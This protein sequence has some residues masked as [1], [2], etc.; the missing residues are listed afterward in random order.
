MKET[1]S[2]IDISFSDNSDDD[3][4]CLQEKYNSAVSK[5]SL[6]SSN[7]TKGL[8]SRDCI[9]VLESNEMQTCG[10]QR[11]KEKTQNVDLFQR[12]EADFRDSPQSYEE[13]DH[14]KD[15]DDFPCM[16]PIS[17]VPSET[18]SGGISQYCSSKNVSP[19][20]SDRLDDNCAEIPAKR[21]KRTAEEILSQKNE[22]LRRKQARKCEL[23]A[24]K[25][26]R[27]KEKQERQLA[28][29]QM[30]IKRDKD[31]LLKK[32][33]TLNQKSERLD[34]CIKQIVVCID[35]DI[36]HG[37]QLSDENTLLQ[38]LELLGAGH[39]IVTQLIPCSVTW[40]RVNVEHTVDDALQVLTKTSYVEE[41]HTIVRLPAMKFVEMVSCFS[42][43]MQNSCISTIDDNESLVNYCERVL[44]IYAEKV[45]TLVIMG[46]EQYFK[47]VKLTNQRQFRNAVLGPSS[48]V[49]EKPRGKGRKKGPE[50]SVVVSRVD[51][52]EALVDLQFCQPN[53]RVRMCETEEEFAE[54]LSMFTKAVAEAPYKKK[55]PDILSFC[56]EGG[57]KAS[58]KVSK[59]GSG[60]KRVWL[61]HFEQF[62]NVSSDMAS[63]IVTVYPSPQSLLQAYYRCNS[64]EAAA[65][66]LQD[67]VVRRGAGV[68][69]TSRRIGPEL[70]RRVHMLFT[71]DNGDLPLK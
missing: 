67:I 58:V 42:Q 62:R 27:E 19:S 7:H 41:R 25:E 8:D 17:N 5:K 32:A 2:I 44:Q 43:E 14:N 45:V 46:L 71:C 69:A 23:Q 54:M 1:S 38:K 50:P 59:D 60:L 51:V 34:G 47:N 65:R 57:E 4:L 26:A 11:T 24:K 28:R 70:S 68:L 36:L 33:E 64:K 21:K 61:Q 13:T 55:Q 66:L 10:S 16:L 39:E 56:V 49:T 29:E 53:C 15:I 37:E 18:Q 3:D 48:S 22:V 35:P 12:K 40:K 63:A 6:Y 30:K 31:K 9:I 52:E 20:S